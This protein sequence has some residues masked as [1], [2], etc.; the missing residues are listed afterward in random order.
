MS[1]SAVPDLPIE[2]ANIDDSSV[3]F[4]DEHVIDVIF[5]YIKNNKI[6]RLPVDLKGIKW[7]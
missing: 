7:H 3:S 2:W 4:E 6:F 1:E 5:D